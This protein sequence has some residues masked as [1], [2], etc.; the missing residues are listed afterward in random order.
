MIAALDSLFS[1][2]ERDPGV[3][4]SDMTGLV[5]QYAHGNEPSHN[6]TWLYNFLGKPSKSQILVRR[7]LDEMYS[8]TP[9]GISGNEDCGQMSAWYVLSS[10][11]IYPVCPGTGEYVFAAPLFKKATVKLWRCRTLWL[12]LIRCQFRRIP[13]G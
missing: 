13:Q 8:P 10:L 11:G 7:M 1:Y 12:C 5:G 4:I 6:M 9:E 2:D 3:K